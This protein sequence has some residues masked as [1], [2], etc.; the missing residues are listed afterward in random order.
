MS[1]QLIIPKTVQKQIDKLSLN[2]QEKVIKTLISLKENARPQNSLKMK[3]SPGYRLRVGEY[4]I[5]YDINDT[6]QTITLRRI[7]HRKDIYRDK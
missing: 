2:I 4:R 5:L 3:N 6:A 7:G 1:Y